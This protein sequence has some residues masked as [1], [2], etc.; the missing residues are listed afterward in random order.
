MRKTILSIIAALFCCS[1]IAHAQD[2]KTPP[3]QKPEEP[4]VIRINTE[5]VQTDVMVFDNHGKF[6]NGLQKEQFELLV[7]GKPQPI[8]FFESVVT[9][10][11]NEAKVLKAA[12]GG[13]QPAVE[14]ALAPDTSERGRTILFFVND[15]SPRTRQPLARTQ[16]HYELHR[17]P[18]W[19]KRPGRHR[20]LQWANRF[21]TTA[22]EQRG[23]VARRARPF[24]IRSGYGA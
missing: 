19:P 15:S 23:S 8:S 13:K 9:G 22:H 12:T 6:V 3:S 11:R 2:K 4:D 5:L 21:S 10:G 20:L 7:D 17:A 1:V 18:A 16:N 14:T 24:E